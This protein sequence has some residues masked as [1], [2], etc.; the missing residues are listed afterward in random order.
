[1]RA[2]IDIMA[3]DQDANRTWVGKNKIGL[4]DPVQTD[5]TYRQNKDHKRRDAMASDSEANDDAVNATAKTL[6]AASIVI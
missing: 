5:V 6:S 3:T 4:F 2:A 1:M